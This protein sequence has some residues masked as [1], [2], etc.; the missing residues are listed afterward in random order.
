MRPPG[1]RPLAPCA[2]VNSQ[3]ARVF[4][5]RLYYGVKPLVPLSARLAVRRWF[6]LRKRDKVQD[7]WPILPGSERPPKGWPGWPV[8]KQF[9][10]VLTHDVEGPAGVAKVRKL[11]ALEQKLGFRSAFNF[12]PEG[13]KYTVSK[14]LRDELAANGFEVGIHD[15]YHNGKLFLQKRE[16]SRNAVK[17]NQYLKDWGAVGFR[18]GFMLHNLDWIHDLNVQY[19]AS[20]FDTDP[21]EPQPQGQHT[22]FPFRVP[23]NVEPPGNK[24]ARA[25]RSSRLSSFAV[26]PA[27]SDFGPRTSGFNSTGYV[28][29]PYTL[30]QDSTLFLILGERHPDIWFQKL[31]WIA[32]HGGMALVNVHPD[33]LRFEDEANSG[34]TYPVEL[35]ACFLN[36]A[37]Q[38]YGDL[39][40]HVN[41]AELASWY[42]R[43]LEVEKPK[44]RPVIPGARFRE[45]WKEQDRLPS[46]TGVLAGK[47]AAVVL[48]SYYATDPRPKREAEAMARAGM[49][50][51]VFCLH[52]EPNMPLHER[53][54]G[55]NVFR[56]PMRRRRESK[57]T[58]VAQ[59]IGFLLGSLALVS[60]RTLWRRYQLVYVHNMPDVLVFSAL[61]PRLLGAKVVLDLHDPMPE[62]FQG[63]YSVR[64]NHIFVRFLKT[65]ERL[66]IAFAHQVITPNSAFK[67]LFVSR[68]C[69]P[70]KIEVVMNTPLATVFHPEEA[71][72]GQP[73]PAERDFVLMYHG[74][75]VERHG[76]DLAVRAVAQLRERLP[77]LKLRFYGE[78]TA[79]MAGVMR[80]A[81]SLNLEDV[82][83]FHRFR[84]QD[85]IAKAI[86]TI[87][88]GIIPNRLNP[89]TAINM[90]TR[91]F[92]Y[93][94]VK[95]PVIVSRTKGI[96]DYF[97]EDSLIFFEP[98]EVE[99]LVRKIE[100]AFLHPA[101][102]RTTLEKGLAVYREHRWELEEQ[103]LLGSLARLLAP[104]RD[105]RHGMPAAARP[106]RICMVT[107]SNYETDNR[108]MRYAEELARQGD[109]VE[110]LALKND[111]S[112]ADT[113]MVGQVKVSRIQSRHR[114]D[115]KTRAAYLLPILRFLIVASLRLAWR[116][117]RR[118]YD[119]VHVHNVPD[120]LVFAAWLPKLAGAKVILDI[121]D[122]LPE[123][124]A[125]KF[126]SP[127]GSLAINTLKLAERK[128][129][130]FADHVIIS[131]HLWRDKYST[132]TGVNGRCSVFI[133]N[134]DAAVFRPRARTRSDGRLIVLFPGGLQWHQ[135]LDIAIR[136]FKRVA[137]K[138]PNAEFHIYGDGNMKDQLKAMTQ[139]LG[140][141][142][143]VRFFRPLPVHQI[144]EIMAN[145][146]LGVVPKRADSFGNEAYSTKIMEF[147]SL[148]VPVVVSSTKI[149]HYYF[150]DSVVRFFESGNHDA[151]AE[152]MLEVL[153]DTGLRRRLVANASEYA[154]R[155]SWESRR[156]DYLSLVDRLIQS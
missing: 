35:Y 67:D 44:P 10:L 17:I 149:D 155:N 7:V 94:A 120:F 14:E 64:P 144:A 139:E 151:L 112:Q 102:V 57:L 128:S 135:G 26:Q 108:V 60:L 77:Q 104:A 79:Y 18:S 45:S 16:F 123:F 137:A 88:L 78:P 100:W 59:Y 92:E 87:D 39:F 53:I 74:L 48:Y 121:H 46:G 80:L 86:T 156:T 115:E 50:V 72:P 136:A 56:F 81:R 95:K 138:L 113:D 33:Y 42:K 32:R 31:D 89:F 143:K 68:G 36:Y 109:T 141:G 22:V 1:A 83:E 142:E 69:A 134:V 3:L 93:L 90:P 25:D 111:P 133:N 152:A 127:S 153:R 30:P 76:L 11:M 82:V 61:L 70:E 99:D 126:K 132:R 47:R 27:D 5:N 12:I 110:V 63:V 103:K 65:L 107:Y 131:N 51:N 105:R 147:M 97:A 28:E 58:Y 145:A 85:E 146:D 4:R 52:R 84:P 29:L 73:A 116:Q 130:R 15:L 2:T 129:A 37:R 49:E 118:P 9:A 20:T 124:Y 43:T 114:K 75:L 66:S 98:G 71:A 38:R 148:G 21:F 117:F 140:L 6:A 106:R 41:P 96:R 54:N 154:A 122:I 55:V 19:D 101:E 23:R 40:W 91:I 8:G 150:D 125:S 13:G 119:L 24:A 62:L 34:M